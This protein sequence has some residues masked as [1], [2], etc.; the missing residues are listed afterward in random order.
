MPPK[1][2]RKCRQGGHQKQISDS[3]LQ[4]YIRGGQRA[5]LGFRGLGFRDYVVYE[6]RGTYAEAA[7]C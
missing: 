6:F 5:G 3:Q 2:A 1:E 7:C 4:E